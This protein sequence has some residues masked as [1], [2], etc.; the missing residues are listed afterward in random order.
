M[1]KTQIQIAIVGVSLLL[2]IIIFQ[3][4]G[5]SRADDSVRADR[6]M[7]ATLEEE[8][9]VRQP[10]QDRTAKQLKEMT[11]QIESKKQKIKEISTKLEEKITKQSVFQTDTK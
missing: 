7:Q 11:E 9:L 4:V 5:T 3:Q 10:Q 8:I 6:N 2:A 1:T